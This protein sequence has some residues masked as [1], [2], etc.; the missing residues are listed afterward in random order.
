MELKASL[1]IFDHREIREGRSFVVTM[2]LIASIA[3]AATAA[4]IAVVI[5]DCIASTIA[6]RLATASVVTLHQIG[7]I[8]LLRLGCHKVKCC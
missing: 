2:V 3:V 6:N 4:S 5:T 8:N 7:S 1:R